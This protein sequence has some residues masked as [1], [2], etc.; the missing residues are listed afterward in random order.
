M[1]VCELC[2]CWCWCHRPIPISIP[3]SIYCVYHLYTFLFLFCIIFSRLVVDTHQCGV[4]FLCVQERS[5]YS[6]HVWGCPHFIYILSIPRTQ[7]THMTHTIYI[8]ISC[9]LN[10][11]PS[12]PFFFVVSRLFSFFFFKK[13]DGLSSLCCRFNQNDTHEK[14]TRYFHCDAL[15]S[16]NIFQ[17]VLDRVYTSLF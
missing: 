11:F 17:C 16:R 15:R 3:I 14:V 5:Y 12:L 13:R 2:E 7:Y 6:M 10:L 8:I 1:C 4:Q 9:L